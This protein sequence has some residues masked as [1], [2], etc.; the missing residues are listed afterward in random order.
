M[1]ANL[2]AV[3]RGWDQEEGVIEPKSRAGRRAV[4]LLAILRRYLEE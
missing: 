3:E 2:I 4:P 1:E